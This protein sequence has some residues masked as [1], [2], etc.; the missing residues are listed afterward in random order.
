MYSVN[1]HP[2]S[3]GLVSVLAVLALS[4]CN[5]GKSAPQA[6]VP[7]VTVVTA[8]QTSVP[9]T[10]ELPG[11][12]SA[13]LVAQVRARVDGIVQKRVYQ[14]GADVKANE[15]LYRI[16]PAP[17]RAALDSA[18]AA[19]QKTQATLAVNVA[20]A[21]RYQVLVSGNAISKQ[22]YDNAVAAQR[23]AAADVA[24]AKAAV[25][26]ATINLGYTDVVSPIAGRSAVSQVTQGAYVQA[27]GATLMTTVQQIDPIYVDL[28]QSS[29]AGLQLRRDVNGGLVKPNGAQQPKVTLTLEDGSTYPMPGALQFSGVTVDPSTGSV[30]VR[31]VFP[32]PKHV[33]LPGMFVRASIE[34]GVNDNAFL[35]PI[36]AVTHNPQGQATALIVGPDNKVVLRVIQAQSTFGANWVVTGGL[37][38]GEKIVVA[39]IQKAP[40]GTLV[41]AVAAPPAQADP[42]A[43][44]TAAAANPA[45]Q[46]APAPALSVAASTAK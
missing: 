29:V 32:N 39:G 13:Y 21:E 18:Q 37:K 1:K 19:L 40:P 27:S 44:Q 4:A 43:S 30:T 12:T 7:E 8:R 42:A 9:V 10:A 22:T 14:E 16:D 38:E 24:S 35:V 31:A 36:P 5:S 45:N 15:L 2:R 20:Q 26:V 34:Q 28:T 46:T 41:H 33:L 3:I 17:Y 11:R 23:Q 25:Q 6:S